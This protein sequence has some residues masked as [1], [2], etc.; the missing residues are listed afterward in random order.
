MADHKLA[1]VPS[2]VAHNPDC[3]TFIMRDAGTCLRHVL[4]QKFSKEY[5]YHAAELFIDM[6]LKSQQHINALLELGVPDYRPAKLAQQFS[7]IMSDQALHETEGLTQSEIK[8]CQSLIP[9]V[10]ELCA[11]AP[12]F[13][14]HATIVQS[15]FSDNNMLINPESKQLCIIDIG[16]IVI[17][18][19]LF[20]LFNAFN[21]IKQLYS[22]VMSPQEQEQWQ[23]HCL[24]R[25]THGSC[26]NEVIQMAVSAAKKILPIYFCVTQYWFRKACG[27]KQLKA[28]GHDKLGQQLRW[29]AS[30]ITH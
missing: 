4:Q 9:T 18:N 25:I 3:H 21:K 11:Q 24:K 6:Q 13:A 12:L 23:Q 2:V 1:N 19:P 7:T 16:E 5:L 28:F 30:N 26:N 15:D 8:H 27:H 17:S 22:Q 10:N 20:S 14:A 29:M